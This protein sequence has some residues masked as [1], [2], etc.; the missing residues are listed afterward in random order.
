MELY[1]YLP[2]L[3]GG[4]LIGFSA[5]MFLSVER[6]HCRHQRHC[7]AVGARA[8]HRSQ[9]CLC[10]G[11]DVGPSAVPWFVRP[12]AHHYRHF[13]LAANHLRG[14]SR[15]VRDED[16]IRMHQRPWCLGSSAIFAPLDSGSGHFPGDGHRYC[17]D[18]EDC[19][20]MKRPYAQ[21]SVA[22]ISGLVFGLGLS[23]SGMLNP[24]RVQGFLDIFGAWDPSLAFV[25]GGAVAVATLGVQIMWRS[26]H[27]LL[28]PRFHVPTNRRIDASLIFGSAMFGI[29][30]GLGGLCPGPALAL[31]PMGLVKPTV[32]V[33]CMVV[34]M[35]VHDRLVR[36][37]QTQ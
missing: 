4:M 3:I 2:A 23:L 7:R 33:V 8:G 22:L 24:Q 9:R 17:N 35:Q 11:A 34:G 30:W 27:P 37:R 31:L 16:G 10:P 36:A 6:P 32:F 13:I 25:L 19:R 18:P 1:P 14:I 29:G 28:E 26:R 5:T 15:R 21:L 12:L 20:T